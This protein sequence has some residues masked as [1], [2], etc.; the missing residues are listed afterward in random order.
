[1]DRMEAGPVLYM[2]YFEHK[3]RR[4]LMRKR[5]LF[6]QQHAFEDAVLRLPM[7]ALTDWMVRHATTFPDLDSYF[8]GYTLSRERLREL[9][10]PADILMAGDDPVVPAEDVHALADL[11]NVRVELTAHGGHCGFIQHAGLDGYAERW[12]TARFLAALEGD[13]LAVES[14]HLTPGERNHALAE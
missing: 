12:V 14:L 4:S 11:P 10:I 3:W 8:D 13:A 1:M 2:R 7:R 9:T 6:P 5:A